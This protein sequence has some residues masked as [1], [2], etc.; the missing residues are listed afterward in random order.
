MTVVKNRFFA[1]A[2]DR[3]GAAAL[4]EVLEGPSAV[5]SGQ[6]PVGTARAAQEATKS[7]PTLQVLGGYAEGHVLDPAGVQKLAELPARDVLLSRT[8]ACMGYPAQRFV[9]S[10]SAIIVKLARVLDQLRK[11]RQEDSAGQD[12]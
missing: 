10:L 4:K 8:L 7:C 12:S 5:I 9:N 11:K 6:D 2:L 3:L 1:I